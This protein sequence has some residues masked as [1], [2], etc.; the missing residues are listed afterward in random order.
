LTGADITDNGRTDLAMVTQLSP[1]ASLLQGVG[2]L[3]F[4]PGGTISN[5][6][7]AT[8]LVA[9]FNGDGMPDVAV[10]SRQGK[11]LLRL[12][13]HEMP[14]VFEAPVI[15]NADPS[16]AARAL[17]VVS[18]PE[19]QVLAA[20]DA[21]LPSLSFYKRRPNGTF[22]R[23]DGPTIPGTLPVALVAG[24]LNGDGLTD[25]VVADAGSDEVLVYLQ[26][27]TG[28]FGPTA[29][30]DL[31]V[32]VSPSALLLVD[33]DGDG[34]LD[35]VVTNQFSGDVSVL[36][37]EGTAGFAS[38]SRFRAGTGLFWL[39]SHDDQIAVRSRLA[40]AG[41]VAGRF[42]TSDAMDVV[43]TNSGVNRFALLRGDGAGGFRNPVQTPGFATGIRPTAVVSG[44]FT[45]GPNLDLAILNEETG[46]I[47]IFLGDGHGGFTEKVLRDSHG[48]PIRLSAGFVP[49]GL[50]AYD[51]NGD[52]KLD[53]LVGNDFGDV[54]ILLGNGDGTFQ[55]YRRS[56]RKVAL[57]V[58]DL[59][60]KGG[61]DFI[62]ADE[63]LD[64]VTVQYAQ[65]A[66]SLPNTSSGTSVLADRTDGLLAPGAVKVADL[67]GDG[68]PDLI[69]ANSGGN[70]LLVY[71]GL[72]NG[73][74][75]AAQTFFTGTNPASVTVA[76]LNDDLVP[77]PSD[78]THQRLFDP[79][80]DLVVANEGSNDVTVL[81]GQGQGNN[82]KFEPGPRL[83]AH[84]SGPV[85]TAVHYTADGRGGAAIP[86]LVIA[87]SQSNTVTM[88]PGV[89]GGFFD[90]RN[91]QVLPTGVDPQQVLVGHFVDPNEVDLVTINAGS[92]DLTF[93]RNFAPG[94]TLS[95]GGEL[96]VAAVAG[97]FNHNGIDDLIV[98]NNGDGRES[99]FLGSAEG[100]VFSR[101]FFNSDVRHPTGLAV[102]V[103]G[104][105][106]QI[107]M[108]DEGKDAAV[109]LTSFAIPIPASATSAQ[110][111]PIA[112]V[113][114]LQGPG[115]SKALDIPSILET[116]GL[117]L[118][119]GLGRLTEAEI[120]ALVV[121]PL[122]IGGG[123]APPDGPPEA[124]Q[125][126]DDLDSFVI[127]QHA[128]LDLRRSVPAEKAI[129]PEFLD[130]VF[131][132]WAPPEDDGFMNLAAE[133]RGA[134][135]TLEK[136]EIAAAASASTACTETS[137]NAS[138]L[139]FSEP[140]GCHLRAGAT[141]A[142]RI[143]D[144]IFSEHSVS[145]SSPTCLP[146]HPDQN[147]SPGLAHPS[148]RDDADLPI[149]ADSETESIGGVSRTLAAAI[150][151]A[152]FSRDRKSAP[153]R[154]VR[155]FRKLPERRYI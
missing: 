66:S 136:T 108:V 10:V 150:L 119:E 4:V 3:N 6:I 112:D 13:R 42:D 130:R 77:D 154:M 122:L 96:P 37:N 99:L 87:N 25:L 17:A 97:D 152:E 62:F 34:R 145:I 92:N 74:F 85:S 140:T 78:P 80:P 76:Y 89:G 60:G 100:L 107:Y 14:G 54:L 52:G 51:V 132:Q 115:F 61:N 29:D 103:V 105:T 153:A 45:G 102:A 79:T 71:P 48:Q 124:E 22:V 53:L 1:D 64:R 133:L 88:L 12:A 86:N 104:D 151:M 26:K 38:E 72:G 125:G 114:V 19:G 118:P 141:S 117:Q 33:V 70:N 90:D 149:L 94:Q 135:V 40:P 111:R 142:R 155:D 15:V 49:T 134:G 139:T 2:G 143:A 24:D 47:S 65:T 28:G 55:S 138:D 137:Q 84:G 113:F 93:F 39:D 128:S 116:A 144:H 41:I 58:A 8:P 109:L 31:H 127:G 110:P 44:R 30:Y 81:Y 129:V 146:T 106:Q 20:L 7:H 67:N 57:A 101:S 35:I 91:P 21:K 16:P 56:D 148:G 63:S 98:A 27:P 32:G 131:E 95:S 5:P 126:N 147:V 121:A 11:I 36:H 68:I 50:A 43:I 73:Q 82:W 23:Q 18:T 59:T 46:D 75:G 123:D 69:V 120:N 83:D 9:D